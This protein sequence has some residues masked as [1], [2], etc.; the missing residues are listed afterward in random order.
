MMI[1]LL[2]SGDEY[3]GSGVERAY[4]SKKKADLI[5]AALDAW[6]DAEP[7]VPHGSDYT[8]AEWQTYHA[9]DKAWH[10]VC[11]LGAEHY[12]HDFYVIHSVETE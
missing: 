10:A 3:E 9:A 7:A 8:D 2:V 11:P 4:R 5:K 12:R 1:H 6:R